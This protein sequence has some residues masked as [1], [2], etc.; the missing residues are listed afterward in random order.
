MLTMLRAS[1]RRLTPL[2]L[3]TFAGLTGHLL[4]ACIEVQGQLQETLLPP[5]ACTSPILC[6]IAQMEGKLRGEA[7]FTAAAVIVSADT[8]VTGVIFVIGDSV[9]VNA[10]LD[11]KRGTLIIKNAA[12][13]RQANGELVD[14]QTIT[15]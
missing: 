3:L 8:P 2:V 4:A 5:P 14:N 11:N 13:F 15:G 9:I 12:A 7:R 6:T 1:H 10:Q